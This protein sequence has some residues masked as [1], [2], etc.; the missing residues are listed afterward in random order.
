MLIAP[1][2]QPKSLTELAVVR[3]REAIVEGDL[4]LGERIS[5]ASLAAALG[6]S[7]TPVREALARLQTEGLV[8]IS[9]RRGTVVFMVSAAEVRAISELRLTLE[10]TALSLAITRNGRS[11]V[12]DLGE[13]VDKMTAADARGDDRQYLRLDAAFH[14]QFFRHC[15]N[16][17]LADAYRLIAAKIAA[18]RTH[19][20][21]RPLQIEDSFAEHRAI[22]EAA[23]EGSTKDAIRVLDHQIARMVRA[24][25]DDDPR[26]VGERPQ[27]RGL[28]PLERS[29]VI[30]LPRRNWSS[31]DAT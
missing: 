23:A 21:I 6:I 9:P 13:V 14:E 3:L 27:R 31:P 25:A 22:L 24:F 20:S 4:A 19:L 1:I 28:A 15:D 29:G 18:L 11:F 16:G 17:Y 30:D 8:T 26:V 7:K 5:E 10:T 12:V 2:D